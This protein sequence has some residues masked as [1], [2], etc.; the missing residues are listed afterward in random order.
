MESCVDR[1]DHDGSYCNNCTSSFD[2]NQPTR[3]VNFQVVIH[4]PCL[5]GLSVL[6]GEDHET[7]SYYANHE[8][9]DQQ[10]SDEHVANITLLGRL[11]K[12]EVAD[13]V[14]DLSGL[15]EEVRD[16]GADGVSAEHDEGH[17]N[18]AA[19]DAC[20]HTD[21]VFV[22]EGL[23]GTY[24]VTITRTHGYLLC[25]CCLL[26][27]KTE[28]KFFHYTVPYQ[29]LRKQSFSSFKGRLRSKKLNSN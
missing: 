17:E 27:W 26:I 18:D 9:D 24:I 20:L 7:N 23:G 13:P 4:N 19:D 28:V 21:V 8:Q 29:K 5:L 11:I 22:A 16:D 3:L 6:G 12:L 2:T 15:L 10:H 1:A 14:V 25:F